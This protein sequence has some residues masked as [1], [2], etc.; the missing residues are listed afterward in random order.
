VSQAPDCS[1]F[2]NMK[3]IEFLA[4][5]DVV[6][7][8]FI[9]LQDARVTCDIN[10]EN[11]TIGMR[12]GDKI[13]YKK[14]T[15]I[16]GVGNSPNASVSASRLGLK[17]A[18]LTHVGA[19]KHGEDCVQAL[20]DNAVDTSLIQKQEGFD[21]NYHYVLSYE[22][23]R[24]ILIK[25]SEFDYDLEKELSE[26][27]SV[28]WMYL[29][30]LAENSLP[31]H[32]E[33]AKYLKDNP[34]TKLAFQPGTFQIKL[35]YEK[36]KDIYESTELFF[37]NKE[38]ANR[39]L[40]EAGKIETAETDMNVILKEMKNL[41]PKI[42]IITDG[43]D[44]AYTYD[45]EQILFVPMYPDPKPPVER[46]GAGDSFS[47]ALTS[48]IAGGMTLEEALLR[49]PINSM[50]VVQNIG[51]QAGLLTKEE[52]E[53]WLEKKPKDYKVRILN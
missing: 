43:P 19:D 21:T 33:I 30:S 47:S 12:F 48:F 10:D 17:S 22:A 23:E 52:I 42:A 32:G 13:P 2:E 49:A 18:I 53:S 50:N 27:E 14:A 5:G 36:L 15:V 28:D 31:H 6:I 37:C 35:G 25:H 39:I 7:D 20:N 45:G 16:E 40:L 4:L 51:A 3:K 1:S 34:K 24:T 46:T 41:G 11:C 29:S 38:E 8:A 26:V 44:G 9:E